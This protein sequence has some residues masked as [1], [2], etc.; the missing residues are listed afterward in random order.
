MTKPKHKL[1]SSFITFI[2]LVFIFTT[3]FIGSMYGSL[4]KARTLLTGQMKSMSVAVGTQTYFSL[5]DAYNLMK[6]ID[7]IMNQYVRVSLYH[8]ADQYKRGV[9]IEEIRRQVNVSS[10]RIIESD[11]YY[12]EKFFQEKLREMKDAPGQV[13][14]NSVLTSGGP[15]GEL[16]KWG[17]IAINDDAILEVGFLLP[18]IINQMALPSDKEI[19]A[20]LKQNNPATQ[21]IIVEPATV[22]MSDGMPHVV[23]QTIDEARVLTIIEAD[24]S[25]MGV[26]IKIT[27]DYPDLYTFQKELFNQTAIQI[28][29]TVIIAMV[30]ILSVA[31]ERKKKRKEGEQDEMV[32]RWIKYR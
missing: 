4:N 10:A 26:R 2:T 16:G 9:S 19:I 18:D 7:P 1:D 8:A 3:F 25:G 28:F 17:Y 31:V 21:E 11:Y 13:W 32:T 27:S 12:N 20:L 29:V 30:V 22:G 5:K 6:S 24:M 15:G 23:S 14:I